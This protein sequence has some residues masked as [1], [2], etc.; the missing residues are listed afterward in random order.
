M[1]Y[2]CLGYYD[3]KKFDALSKADVDALV[4]QCGPFDAA[5]RQTGRVLLTASLGSSK[6]ST[7]LRPKGGKVAV[8]DGPYAETKEQ[9][10]GFFLIEADSQEE[11]IRVA[12]HHPAAHLGEAVGWGVE[13][14]PIGTFVQP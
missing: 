11:A 1:K 5:L 6:A 4:S 7:S 9:I 3:E 2:L 13:V 14:R 10:G 12:S 8:T